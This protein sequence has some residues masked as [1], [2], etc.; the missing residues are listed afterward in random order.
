METV[1]AFGIGAFVG[2]I[3]GFGLASEPFDEHC[4]YTGGSV[5]GN[6][7]LIDGQVSITEDEF[8]E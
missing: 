6:V 3:I 2:C 7:C 5:E 8:Y 4:R 1:I